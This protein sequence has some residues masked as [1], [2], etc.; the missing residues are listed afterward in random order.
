M[1]KKAL[2]F[3]SLGTVFAVG[4]ATVTLSGL[5]QLQKSNELKATGEYEKTNTKVNITSITNVQDMVGEP[6]YYTF[7]ASGVSPKGAT[8][9]AQEYDADTMEGSWLYSDGG[10]ESFDYTSGSYM[11]KMTYTASNYNAPSMYLYVLI[12]KKAELN[13][14]DSYLLYDEDFNSAH[15][16]TKENQKKA[17]TLYDN[18][19]ENYNVYEFKIE[20]TSYTVGGFVTVHRLHL[21]Y[22]C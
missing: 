14:V 12:H 10:L 22:L 4:V 15:I 13:L 2:L 16:P 17:G 20:V 1:N 11:L 3:V 8:I 18:T 5:N 7:S 21:E 6:D 19:K 9:Y